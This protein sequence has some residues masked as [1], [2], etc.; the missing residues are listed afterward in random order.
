MIDR[1][2]AL[3][4]AAR[5]TLVSS[6]VT[7]GALGWLALSLAAGL[8]WPIAMVAAEAMAPLLLLLAW[9]IA[10]G[11]LVRRHWVLGAAATALAVAHVVV[12]LPVIF[13]GSRPTW[14]S[15]GPSVRVLS[16]NVKADNRQPQAAAKALL[17]QHADVLVVIEATTRF[18]AQL[19]RLDVT[20]T[21]PFQSLHPQRTGYGT[22]IFSKLPLHEVAL[23]DMNGIV[24][25]QVQLTV[26]AT[27][28]DL[29]AVHTRSPYAESRVSTWRS[30]L[31]RLGQLADQL[32]SRGVL[33]G[34]F[35]AARWHTPF[36]ELLDHGLTDAHLVTGNGLSRSWPN[37]RRILPPLFRIDHA[38]MRSGVTARSVHNVDIPGSDHIA[39]L[40]DLVVQ[41]A[42]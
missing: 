17:A 1:P 39:F 41:P 26:G 42:A 9:P 35:N 14:L 15:A 21:Y 20:A 31:H 40:V 33:V 13:H 28:L 11:A 23:G 34:D 12:L 36:A 6:W 2:R 7:V 25:P 16:A 8:A 29:M 3:A 27:T 5:T 37:D 30:D 22:A 32:P 10:V 19:D 38:L 4:L 24:V 18:V